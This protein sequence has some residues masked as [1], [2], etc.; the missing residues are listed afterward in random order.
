MSDWVLVVVGVLMFSVCLSIAFGRWFK[1]M[2][3]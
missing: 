3:E 1:R 2:G